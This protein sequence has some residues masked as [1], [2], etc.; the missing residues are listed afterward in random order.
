MHSLAG[1]FL[2][3]VLQLL[4]RFCTWL[5]SGLEARSAPHSSPT[6]GDG[7]SDSAAGRWAVGI[8]ADQ[9]CSLRADTEKLLDWLDSTYRD[10]LMQMLPS[11]SKKVCLGSTVECIWN[12]VLALLA[13]RCEV[14]RSI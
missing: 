9:L 8:K 3:L 10:Q 6:G 7:I 13:A 2:R 14:A 11:R 5:R 1:R 12:I 4:S